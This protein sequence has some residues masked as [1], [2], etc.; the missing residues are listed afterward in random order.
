[1]VDY[2]GSS[3]PPNITQLNIFDAQTAALDLINQTRDQIARNNNRLAEINQQLSLATINT[4]NESNGQQNNAASPIA[5]SD[6]DLR[7]RLRA[8]PNSRAY[9][10]IYDGNPW[11]TCKSMAA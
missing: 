8:K 7:A 11:P 3:A 1:M 5:P 6:F 10:L 9:K 4:D 2:V